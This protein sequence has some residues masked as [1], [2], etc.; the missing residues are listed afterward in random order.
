MRALAESGNLEGKRGAYRL[1]RPVDET[2]VPPTVQTVLAAR[3]DRLA[4][5]EKACFRAPR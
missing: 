2:A 1:V 3:I 4:E 5:R